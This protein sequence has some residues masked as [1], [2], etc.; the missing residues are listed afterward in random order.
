MI[1]DFGHPQLDDIIV[2]EVPLD[3]VD[4][5]QRAGALP[6]L[7]P[8]LFEHRPPQTASADPPCCALPHLFSGLA[9]FLGQEPITDLGVI[10]MGV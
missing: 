10:D 2:G 9:G 3:E 7:A 5:N 1:G 4:M 6:I 8:L